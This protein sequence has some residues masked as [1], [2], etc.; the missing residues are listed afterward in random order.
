MKTSNT[1]AQAELD[2]S[3]AP[4][5]IDVGYASNSLKRLIREHPV[6]RCRSSFLYHLH[7]NLC[8]VHRNKH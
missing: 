4:F 8:A 5:I 2:Y 3:K 7:G 6:N 1:H